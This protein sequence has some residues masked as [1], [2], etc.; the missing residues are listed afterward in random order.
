M[1]S[2]LLT[3]LTTV[4]QN[5]FN[6]TASQPTFSTTVEEDDNGTSSS[7]VTTTTRD[8]S[9]VLTTLFNDLTTILQASVN[10]TTTTT[11]TQQQQQHADDATV[12][13][14]P[15]FSMDD[16]DGGD[17]RNITSLLPDTMDLQNT[18]FTFIPLIT[19]TTKPI[20]DNIPA[21][22][23]APATETPLPVPSSTTTPPP[24]ATP[25]TTT[26]TTTATTS[27]RTDATP[28]PSGTTATTSS[29]P[30]S[31]ELTSISPPAVN[32]TTTTTTTAATSTQDRSLTARPTTLTTTVRP[33]ERVV[34]LVVR[35]PYLTHNGYFHPHYN[36][37]GNPSW[38]A[39][40]LYRFGG[41]RRLPP[42]LTT[43]LNVVRRKKQNEA[44]SQTRTPTKAR[45]PF[46]EAARAP[47]PQKPDPDPSQWQGESPREKGKGGDVIGRVPST[48]ADD[49]RQGQSLPPPP[50]L[51]PH[52]RP[53]GL[54]KKKDW[55]HHLP[56]GHPHTPHIKASDVSRRPAPAQEPLLPRG[57]S[58]PSRPPPLPKGSPTTSE[59]RPAASPTQSKDFS[60][61][62]SVSSSV[63]TPTT[64]TTT[65]T[66]MRGGPSSA[67]ALRG[68]LL[69]PRLVQ[70]RGYGSQPWR[71]SRR[72]VYHLLHHVGGGSVA[73]SWSHRG[74]SPWLPTNSNRSLRDKLLHV[75]ARTRG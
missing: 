43:L 55:T 33:R 35:G 62:G 10:S 75:L 38:A 32:T 42:G 44:N 26:T 37:Q 7:I 34:V 45:S 63:G 50:G 14:S 67:G 41:G 22:T 49:H 61:P 56:P 69:V 64:T 23:A 39:R 6:A 4:L 25:D 21:N 40:F 72:R 58:P 46:K 73:G 16:D 15:Q 5:L 20:E 28:S 17:E 53:P 47:T 2:T 57:S 48:S 13:P 66:I 54:A 74:S 8:P 11:K 31:T 18:D 59:Q 12:S 70:G 27:T 65:T 1:T 71:T 9:N 51:H 68:S 24:T 19:I 29:S 36:R 52:G 60:G 30:M 3:G